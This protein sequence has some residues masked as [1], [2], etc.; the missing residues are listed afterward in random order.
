MQMRSSDKESQPGPLTGSRLKLGRAL[1]S[2]R[3][4]MVIAVIGALISSLALIFYE[5]IVL[6][7]GVVEV[8]RE[9]TVSPEAS[10][11]LAIRLV[12]AVDVFLIAIT[13]YIT[14]LGLY[15]LFIDDSLSLPRWLEVHELEDLKR[16]LVSLVIVVLAVLFLRHVMA[17]EGGYDI[18]GLGAA[19]ALVIVALTF[20]LIRSGKQN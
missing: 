20:F 18:A 15:A 9:R 1:S 12:E 4:V 3:Y 17:W 16:S 11:V 7:R 13:V 2:S 8:I 6:A 19:L 14:G 10:K 5:A